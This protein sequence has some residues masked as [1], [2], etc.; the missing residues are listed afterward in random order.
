MLIFSMLDKRLCNSKIYCFQIHFVTPYRKIQMAAIML[1]T[2][3]RFYAKISEKNLFISATT[4]E[5]YI[6][7]KGYCTAHH[8]EKTCS[9]PACKY[10]IKLPGNV[11]ELLKELDSFCFT[12][13]HVDCLYTLFKYRFS[14]KVFA[15][16]GQV[17]DNVQ[18]A[19]DFNNRNKE[20]ERMPSIAKKR[21]LRKKC[22]KHLFS[23]FQKTKT[24][25]TSGSVFAER[26]E[27]VKK[28]K[29][30]FELLKIVDCFLDGHGVFDSILV[31]FKTKSL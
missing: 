12:Y 25:Q 2:I 4:Y 10:H 9:L 24:T 30:E 7:C 6:V 3:P 19:V 11:Q 5:K 17:F 15:K 20:V 8:N 22:K 26:I 28:T 18:R 29:F 14:G 1:Q 27:K 16:S 23:F 31:S 13:Q 21:L